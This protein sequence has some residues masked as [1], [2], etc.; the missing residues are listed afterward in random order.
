MEE[1]VIAEEAAIP[2]LKAFIEYHLDETIE[3]SR[4]K[5]DYAEVLKALTLGNLDISNID[6]PVLKLKKPIMR[7][8]GIVDTDE[9]KFLTRVG[10]NKL[11]ELARGID[12]TKDSLTF[13][14]KMT[15]YLIQ[16]P[17]MAMLD[18]YG[19]SDLK[20]IDKVVGLF[21]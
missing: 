15:A 20:I 14:N 21:L 7:E 5:D 11:A 17:V 19:K 18:K 6:A 13:A 1:F 3:E 10:K 16:Q 12:M 4:V 8:N 2:E 9:V